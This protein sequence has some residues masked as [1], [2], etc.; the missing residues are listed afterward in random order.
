MAYAIRDGYQVTKGHT[1]FIPKRH[2]M[3]YFELVQ[4]EA[5]AINAL[6]L[7]QK[8]LLQSKDPTITGFNIGMNCGEDAGQTIFHCHVHLIPRRK[9]DVEKPRGG[10]RHIIP[11][12]G[13]Y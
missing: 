1:L 5:N 12:K 10:V 8:S 6:M 4:A 9:G 3:D 7:E 13:H 11:G 2:A